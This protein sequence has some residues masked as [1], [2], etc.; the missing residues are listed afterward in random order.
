MLKSKKG[1]T[2]IELIIVVAIMAVLVALLAPNVLKY[3]EKSKVAKD[4]NTLDSVRLA[5]EAEIM[6]EDLCTLSTGLSGTKIRGI[7]MHTIQSG[8]GASAGFKTLHDR[9]FNGKVLDDSLK[10][11]KVWAGPTEAFTSQTNISQGGRIAIYLDGKGGVAVAAVTPQ[12]K[13]ISYDGKELIVYTKLSRES[14]GDHV[15]SLGGGEEF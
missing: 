5:I 10:T 1:F 14:I 11:I 15:M 7:H 2:L 8:S 13:V 9:I 4:I 12:G 6:D 3:L